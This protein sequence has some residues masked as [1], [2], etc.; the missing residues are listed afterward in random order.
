M[1]YRIRVLLPFVGVWLSACEP[2]DCMHENGGCDPHATCTQTDEGPTCRCNTGFSGDGRACVVTCPDGSSLIDEAPTLRGKISQW[3]QGSGY[4]LKGKQIPFAGV[5]EGDGT[6]SVKLYDRAQI[7]PYLKEQDALGN[8]EGCTVKGLATPSRASM[9]LNDTLL[10][11]DPRAQVIGRVLLGR[12]AT[13]MGQVG[14]QIVYADQEVS[15]QAEVLCGAKSMLQVRFAGILERG[16]N[17]KRLDILL[18]DLVGRTE[19]QVSS[20]RCIPSDLVYH[21]LPGE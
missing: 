6:F 14:T 17:L 12:P 16:Y 5:I 8:T 3:S 11:L 10:V 21:M 2:M 13:P 19:I 7:L 15:L 4:T 18:L 1:H 9:A 20:T